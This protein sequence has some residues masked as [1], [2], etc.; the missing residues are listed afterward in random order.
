VVWLRSTTA[1]ITGFTSANHEF[2]MGF[3]YDLAHG[4]A[5]ALM[6]KAVDIPNSFGPPQVR[7]VDGHAALFTEGTHFQDAH[8][9]PSLLRMDLDH[10]S[11]A[12][13]EQGSEDTDGFVLGADGQAVAQTTWDEANKRWTLKLKQNGFWHEVRAE[14]ASIDTPSLMGLGR[15]GKSVLVGE[16]RGDDF[17]VRELSPDGKWSEPLPID[18]G[19]PELIFDPAHHNLIGYTT[20]IGDEQ[21]TVFFDPKDQ[22]VWDLVQHAYPGQRVQL[23]SWSDDRQ[24]IVVRAD[25]P[26]DG[27]GYAL[28]DLA[29]HHAD[30]LGNDYDKIGPDDISPR[31]AIAFKAA[32][33][34]E[35]TGYLTVPHGRDAKALPLV[36]LPHGGPQARDEPGFDWLAEGIAS[37]GYAVLQVNYRGSD[38][39]GEKFVAEGYGQWGR[40]MQTDLSD[41]VRYLAGQ[42][43]VDPKRV[44]IV[45]ASYGGYAALAGPT[46]DPGV[47]R[48]AVSYAG[49]ADLHAMVAW[50]QS[51]AGGV[52]ERYWLRFMGAKSLGDPSL[53]DISP[54]AH[55]Q[56]VS[57]P[58]LLIHGKDDT[59]VP[60]EQSHMMANDMKAAGKPV[61]MVVLD[62]T[63]HWLTRGATRLAMLQDAMAFVEKNNPPN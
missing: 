17:I 54:T 49:P 2:L 37:R 62:S 51:H 23:A 58:V 52:S 53:A 11:A 61:E 44:C 46:L 4:T 25:S 18:G 29:A 47:Y 32:D 7:T 14:Q 22:Q 57:V 63:D 1:S 27:P 42:G 34:T 5:R 13:V 9:Y 15:D 41:G 50:S 30:W 26:T 38:G 24:K 36:V 59:V 20:L 16:K 21:R 10:E 39:F 33:G 6:D 31:K 35:L 3:E 56:K 60:L 8:S 45:G 55:V 43:I 48:C 12:V 40:K 28:V 19:D